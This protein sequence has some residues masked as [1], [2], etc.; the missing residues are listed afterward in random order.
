MSNKPVTFVLNLNPGDAHVDR[1]LAM[2]DANGLASVRL[3]PGTRPGFVRVSCT[4]EGLSASVL[5][6]VLGVP[7]AAP[8]DTRAPAI[9]PP[10]TGDAGLASESA[11]NSALMAAALAFAA[12]LGAFAYRRVAERA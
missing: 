8:I 6:E 10:R 3:D 11:G 5:V 9:Q 1:N 4:G 12:T 7:P 2:T